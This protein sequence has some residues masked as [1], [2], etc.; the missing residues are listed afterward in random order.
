MESIRRELSGQPCLDFQIFENKKLAVS[1]PVPGWFDRW[2]LG[3]NG[4][5]LK[6]HESNDA[7]WV[8]FNYGSLIYTIKIVNE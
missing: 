6:Y 8:E 2:R 3:M 4:I 1:N 7:L 5:S